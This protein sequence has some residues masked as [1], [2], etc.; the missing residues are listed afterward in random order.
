MMGTSNMQAFLA[1]IAWS[2]IGEMAHR[3]DRGYSIIV[4][5]RP[6]RIIKMKDYCD[7]P[8]VSVQLSKKL[9]S[10][11]AGRYQILERTFDAYRRELSLPDFSPAS[12]DAIAHRLIAERGATELIYAGEIEEAI[13]RV[14]KIWASLPGAG[15]GQNENSL[16]KLLSYYNGALTSKRVG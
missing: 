12:Q 1:T 11:A 9:W 8:R 5:S 10:T 13:T 15:Y 14:N 7:H 4:G 2:E 3:K 6:G 16:E